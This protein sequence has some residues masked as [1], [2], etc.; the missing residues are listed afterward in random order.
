M[1]IEHVYGSDFTLTDSN[2]LAVV[3]DVDASNERI[4]RRLLTSIGDYFW[5]ETYGCG[6]SSYI[7]KAMSSQIKK[8][9]TG[10]IL[11]QIFKE[12]TVAKNPAPVID[13]TEGS[14]DLQCDIKYY[15]VTDQQLVNLNFKISPLV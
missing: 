15:S 4:I 8:E 1:D 13:F 12:A 14:G 5:E 9:L 6:V 7:G 10:I 3:M 11:T 2:D